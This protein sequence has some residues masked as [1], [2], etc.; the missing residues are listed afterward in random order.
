MGPDLDTQKL[1]DPLENLA[2]GNR[3]IIHVKH[4]RN[5]LKGKALNLL[6]GHNP[7][8]E[9]QCR[10]HILSEDCAI[11]LIGH[12]AAVI[13]CAVKHQSR[14]TAFLIDPLRPLFKIL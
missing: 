4:V 6:G 7:K 12:T 10:F 5:P 11:L 13:D 2:P 14:T 1:H 8:Q 9:P 3:S